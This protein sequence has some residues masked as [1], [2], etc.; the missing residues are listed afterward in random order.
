MAHRWLCVCVA[1]TKG[2]NLA[3]LR[4]GY[5]EISEWDARKFNQLRAVEV[6]AVMDTVIAG[7][8]QVV[9]GT[10]AP[11]KQ[12]ELQRALG[13][14]DNE[15]GIL[16]D[17]R[18]KA[19]LDPVK[20]MTWDWVHNMFNDGTFCIEVERFMQACAPLGVRRSDVQ[21]FLKD[22][23][24]FFPA[25]SGSKSRGLH[26]VFNVCRESTVDNTKIKANASEWISL[27][28]LFRSPGTSELCTGCD[29]L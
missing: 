15:H 7:R 19:I 13:L 27:V 24:W 23:A 2:S 5:V 10:L 21:D 9:A 11:G 3:N 26:H 22:P 29:R 17:A 16:A 4:P 20:I 1:S 12:L 18:L 6:F 28:G 14:N 8:E 25:S